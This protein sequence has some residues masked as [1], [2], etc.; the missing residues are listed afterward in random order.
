[1]SYYFL[2]FASLPSTSDYLKENWLSLPSKTVVSAQVQTKGHGRLGR[3]WNASEGSLTFSLLLKGKEYLPALPLLPL[4][5]GAAVGESLEKLGASPMLKWP[6]DVYLNDKKVA[7]I[8]VE[9]LYQ[10]QEFLGAIIGIGVN[11]NNSSFPA[12]LEGATSLYLESKIHVETES[13]LKE[14][15]DSLEPLLLSPEKALSF[16]SSHDYLFGKEI[17]LNYYGED[18]TGISRGIDSQGR[19]LLE[20]NGAIITVSSGEA[21]LHPKNTK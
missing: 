4:A 16:F 5:A 13:L 6:N 10:G 15:L 1:M 21:T 17:R 20:N 3:S 14:I 11:V 7:G 9:S 12:E 19:L 8:L 18:L 2:S